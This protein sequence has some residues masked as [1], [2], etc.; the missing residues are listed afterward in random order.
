MMRRVRTARYFIEFWT[1]GFLSTCWLRDYYLWAGHVARLESSRGAFELTRNF[2][3][4]W[5]QEALSSLRAL[6]VHDKD[7][8]W[9]IRIGNGFGA[10]WDRRISLFWYS[11]EL[12]WWYCAQ[13]REIWER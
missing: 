2:C 10:I 8:R 4:Q 6:P 1:P 9:T 3:L 12:I 7:H 5:R 11:Q 13:N